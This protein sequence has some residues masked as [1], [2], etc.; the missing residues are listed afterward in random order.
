MVKVFEHR[1]DCY[2]TFVAC[3]D[4]VSIHIDLASSLTNVVQHSGAIATRCA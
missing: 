4:A 3:R 1:L 2:V